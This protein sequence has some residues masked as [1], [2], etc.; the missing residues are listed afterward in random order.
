[1]K[2]RDPIMI[3]TLFILSM[4]S[5]GAAAALDKRSG[6]D[7]SSKT[8]SEHFVF[9]KAL[10]RYRFENDGKGFRENLVGVRILDETG[11]RQW[12]QLTF[13]YAPRSESLYIAY[14]RVARKGAVQTIVSRLVQRHKARE[15]YMKWTFDYD[16]KRVRLS[17][18]SPGDVV[19]YDVRTIIEVPKAVGQFW[20]QHTFQSA[21]NSRETLEVDVPS[22][23]N[24]KI[25]S[26]STLRTLVS[27]ERGRRIYH[28]QNVKPSA[29]ES[30]G[31]SS[32]DAPDVQLTSF[33]DWQQVGQWYANLERPH[34]IPSPEVSAKADELTQGLTD[35]LEKVKA[36]YDFTAKKIKYMSL[37]SLGVGGYEPHSASDTLRSRTGDCKDKAALLVALLHAEDIRAASVLINSHREPSL[38]LFIPSMFNHVIVVVSLN[39][40]E[41]WVDPSSAILPF[42]MLPYELRWKE[43]LVVPNSGFPYITKTPRDAPFTNTWTETVEAE[44][45]NDGSLRANVRMT[46]RG[47]AEL[48]LRQ[49]FIGPVRSMWP[50]VVQG[51]ISHYSR[52]IS[53]VDVTDPMDTDVPFTISFHFTKTRFVDLSSTGLVEI[54]LPL[55]NLLAPTEGRAPDGDSVFFRVPGE[56]TYRITLKLPTGLVP[57]CPQPVVLERDFAR[58]K[59]FYSSSGTSISVE[60]S[61]TIKQGELPAILTGEYLSFRR[62]TL[63]DMEQS[64]TARTQ[65]PPETHSQWF[66]LAPTTASRAP[67]E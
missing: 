50:F 1:M 66:R 21:T 62:E 42:R 18:L 67:T 64:V 44:V 36:L 22:G 35:N 61:L 63:S 33:E 55:G 37:E 32:R 43:G 10:T 49:Q 4:F 24:V 58:Y 29:D 19:E 46:A 30:Q 14:V 60:R 16:E 26:V 56:R 6:L 20:I 59:A 47:D 2:A 13:D 45:N 48:S 31:N 54:I 23:R 57:N 11:A 28:W 9:E 40:H 52:D 8:S 3:G 7:I 5:L 17:Q 34:I 53:A 39:G 38:E 51:I 27:E 12:Q 41:I 15:L 65:I 25:K